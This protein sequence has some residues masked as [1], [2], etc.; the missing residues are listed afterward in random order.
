MSS[1]RFNLAAVVSLS[2]GMVCL[3]RLQ[4]DD[5]AEN[6][7]VPE[8]VNAAQEAF[9]SAQAEHGFQQAN[10]EDLYQW[11]RR[12]MEAEQASG[13]NKKAVLDHVTRMRDLHAR[14]EAL[15]KTGAKGG[16][17]FRYH[18]TRYYLLEAEAEALK[19]AN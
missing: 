1:K 3:S 6:E 8:I 16:S 17:A 12:L 2:L 18:A 14:T 4:A 7:D 15:F 9:K 19:L 5:P 10:V 11:S 13:K